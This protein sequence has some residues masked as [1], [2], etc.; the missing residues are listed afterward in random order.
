MRIDLAPITVKPPF[1]LRCLARLIGGDAVP[2]WKTYITFSICKSSDLRDHPFGNNLA[3]KRY[4]PSLL[5]PRF[6]ADV[7]SQIYFLEIDIKGI[8][9]EPKSLVWRN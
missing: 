7:E 6:A 9:T 4:A 1:V 5:I 2:H 8:E 3:D